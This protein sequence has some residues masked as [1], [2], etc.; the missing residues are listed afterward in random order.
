MYAGMNH[1]GQPYEARCYT[2]CRK[3]GGKGFAIIT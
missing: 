3:P 2:R 1:P